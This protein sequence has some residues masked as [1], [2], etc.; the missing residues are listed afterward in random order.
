MRG[1]VWKRRHFRSLGLS[2]FFLPLNEHRE[3]SSIPGGF[4][5]SKGQESLSCISTTTLPPVPLGLPLWRLVRSSHPSAKVGR[6]NS[7]Q[8]MSYF[9]LLSLMQ[10]VDTAFLSKA[11][12]EGQCG[13]PNSGN[14]LPENAAGKG[15][16][17]GAI[18]GDHCVAWTPG[19]FTD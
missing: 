5:L 4:T 9:I 8:I 13:H 17:P 18:Q 11:D 16:S 12:L 7:T 2:R 1:E 3:R 15:S 10:D 6:L 14:R 19:G